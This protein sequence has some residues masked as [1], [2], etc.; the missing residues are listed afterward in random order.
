MLWS[1]AI[2]HNSVF[3]SQ[4]WLDCLLLVGRKTLDNIFIKVNEHKTL[5]HF[6]ILSLPILFGFILYL[7]QIYKCMLLYIDHFY[8]LGWCAL[9]KRMR[10]RVRMRLRRGEH[11]ILRL[12]AELSNR[13]AY[14]E[15]CLN[16]QELTGMRGVLLDDDLYSTTNCLCQLFHDTRMWWCTNHSTTFAHTHRR[17]T[18]G[19]KSMFSHFTRFLV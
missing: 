17:R 3:F 9:W 18:T 6:V 16:V 11:S 13:H 15:F 19:N 10:I 7:G 12:K 14:T 4:L 1:F 8:L 5:T 2:V